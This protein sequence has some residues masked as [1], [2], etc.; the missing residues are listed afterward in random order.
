MIKKSLLLAAFVFTSI[1]SSAQ[2]NFSRY[3]AEAA[4]NMEKEELSLAIDKFSK[5]IDNK[6]DAPNNYKVADAYMYRGY[7]KY[8][9][10]NYKS[11]IA[12]MDE[13]LK[14]K[15]EYTKVYTLK[16][17]VYL[18][19][20][21][22]EEC[23]ATCDK[24]LEKNP[25]NDDLL[26]NKSQAYFFLKKYK[27]SLQP[28]FAMLEIDP[29]DRKALTF[30]GSTF[31][32]QKIYDSSIVYFSKA[33]EIDPLDLMSLYN[34]GIS[35]S[36][37]KDTAAATR[38]MLRAMQLDTATKFVG[39]NNLAFYLK[40]EKKDFT[41]AIEYFNKAIELNPNFAYAYSNRGF[42]KLNLNDIKGAYKDLR[43]SIELDNTN[44]YAF[45]N[46]GL[47]Y[48]KDGQKKNACENFK[49]AVELGYS[50]TY[51]DEVEK[52]LKENCN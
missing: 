51:D 1:L 33:L 38:D 11:A 10:Q 3:F 26:F 4:Q 37:T 36:Y 29:R 32:H 15:P 9:Q 34:R 25:N 48:L 16:S 23:I 7:C 39:Y 31:L 46:L 20:K 18:A 2:N 35:R 14:V 17:N 40:L 28:L 43:K 8:L 44:S 47:I 5:A 21:K 27:E 13:A 22:Y 52:L 41:G 12:D 42:A 50:D 6:N 19:T 45:K 49:K 30:I 24:G